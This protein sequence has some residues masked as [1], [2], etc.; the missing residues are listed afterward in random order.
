MKPLCLLAGLL[1]L[2]GCAAAPPAQD[3]V[4]VS[5]GILFTLPSPANLGRSV[6]VAQLVTAVYPGGSL[7]FEARVAVTP[8]RL[9]LTGTD[10]LGLRLL[11]IV[12]DGRAVRVAERAPW[13]PPHVRTENILA[14][15][16]MMAAPISLVQRNLL[17]ATV[18]TDSGVSEICTTDG[19][20]IRISR[21]N[22]G[23]SGHARIEN[24]SRNYSLDIQSVEVVP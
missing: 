7:V 16:L 4:E 21:D 1:A 19:P 14:D 8:E 17:G 18:V 11:T 3:P 24:L 13:L 5:P 22:D 20:M 2:L 9:M 10:T 12:W 23:W 6:E 15:V